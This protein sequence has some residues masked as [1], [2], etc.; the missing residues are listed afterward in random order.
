MAVK[1]A[2]VA[3]LTG[4]AVFLPLAEDLRIYL[5]GLADAGL[6]TR[7]EAD[8]LV[9]GRP[10]DAELADRLLP[11]QVAFLLDCQQRLT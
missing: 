6:L 10:P 8:E 9:A 11:G 1:P 4:A 7:D 2:T 3:H 5:Y